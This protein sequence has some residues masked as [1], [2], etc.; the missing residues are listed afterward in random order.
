M[1]NII[2]ENCNKI[3]AKARLY[4]GGNIKKEKVIKCFGHSDQAK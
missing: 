3:G 2:A 4:A 1:K